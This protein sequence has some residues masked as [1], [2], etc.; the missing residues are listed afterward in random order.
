MKTLFKP[1]LF[2]KRKR[3]WSMLIF[4]GTEHWFCWKTSFHPLLWTSSGLKGSWKLS[5]YIRFGSLRSVK[6]LKLMVIR[7]LRSAK[8]VKPNGN[9]KPKKFRSVK[10]NWM[11]D[12][13]G[14]FYEQVEG[15]AMGSPVSPIVANLYMEYLEQKALSTAPHPPRF[16]HRYVDDTFV[17]HKEANKTRCPATH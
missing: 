11:E 15:A 4:S 5:T 9:W 10:P 3:Y 2:D 6:V 12:M 7:S 17:I 14:Q 13:E 16:W 1:R 8:S